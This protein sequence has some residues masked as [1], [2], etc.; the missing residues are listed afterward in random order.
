MDCENIS[1][2]V[3]EWET[4]S[5]SQHRSQVTNW[6]L[7]IFVGESLRQTV[8]LWKYS[9]HKRKERSYAVIWIS[10]ESLRATLFD[11]NYSLSQVSD[12]GNIPEIWQ[13][14][15]TLLMKKTTDSLNLVA[16]LSFENLW[17]LKLSVSRSRLGSDR[18][19]VAE[20]W[21]CLVSTHAKFQ[22]HPTQKFWKWGSNA[23]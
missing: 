13:T 9:F 7:L 20:I 3:N 6:Q 5:Q 10:S 16:R 2:K 22:M 17:L 8:K 15:T 23:R 18:D 1:V 12:Y 19:F 4:T 21:W 14:K 11:C